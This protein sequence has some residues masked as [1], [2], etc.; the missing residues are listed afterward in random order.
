MRKE[1]A[2]LN[3]RI[4][5]AGDAVTGTVSATVPVAVQIINIPWVVVRMI[6]EETSGAIDQIIG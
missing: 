3:N 6:T 2:E 1:V 5:D 4:E